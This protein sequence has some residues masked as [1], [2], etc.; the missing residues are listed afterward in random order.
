LPDD[1]AMILWGQLEQPTPPDGGALKAELAALAPP[2][3]GW[4]AGGNPPPESAM[5]QAMSSLENPF[6]DLDRFTRAVCDAELADLTSSIPPHPLVVHSRREHHRAEGE[7]LTG[8]ATAFARQNDMPFAEVSPL[9]RAVGGQ[10]MGVMNLL[11]RTWWPTCP[12]EV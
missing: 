11:G 6:V 4:T 5:P 10:M 7:R 8:K 1:E 12:E 2:A 9:L 3:P